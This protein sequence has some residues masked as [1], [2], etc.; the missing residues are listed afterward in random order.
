MAKEKERM[1]FYEKAA[2]VSF[3]YNVSIEASMSMVTLGSKIQKMLSHGNGELTEADQQA[4]MGDLKNLTGVS[5][6]E[7]SAAAEDSKAKSDVLAKIASKIGTSAQNLEQ[8]F[9]P[10]VFGITL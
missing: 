5:L 4:L 2:R 10:E 8:K 7:I 3:A 6:A 9:L 1:K